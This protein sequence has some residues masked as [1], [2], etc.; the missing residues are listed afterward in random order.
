MMKRVARQF[1]F[2]RKSN[3]PYDHGTLRSRSNRDAAQTF[4]PVRS[5]THLI[6]IY[7]FVSSMPLIFPQR[8]R[9][10]RFIVFNAVLGAGHI[11]VLFSVGSYIALMPHVAGD[12]GGVFPSFGTWAQTLFIIA[13]ALAF[14]INRWLSGRFGDYRVF[15]AAFVAYALASYLCAISETLWLFLPSRVFLGLRGWHYPPHRT[16]TDAAGISATA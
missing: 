4:L 13:L 9:G 15:V 12:L 5:L 6:S 10:W 7:D 14:P 16:G 2:R 11:I 8:L 1:R 3:F